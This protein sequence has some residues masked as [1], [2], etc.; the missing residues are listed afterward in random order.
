MVT[1][2]KGIN[3]LAQKRVGLKDHR[4]IYYP[5]KGWLIYRKHKA[6][7]RAFSLPPIFKALYKFFKGFYVQ[8][9]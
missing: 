4:K 5:C 7:A 6:P 2:L 9:V 3:S 8:D 1:N